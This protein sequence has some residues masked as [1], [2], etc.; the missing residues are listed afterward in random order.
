V[1]VTGEEPL[2]LIGDLGDLAGIGLVS[3]LLRHRIEF[4]NG[5]G[6][7]EFG[8]DVQAQFGP[9]LLGNGNEP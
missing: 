9:R 7:E 5:K 1:L 8:R 6:V 4:G 2:P 3:R